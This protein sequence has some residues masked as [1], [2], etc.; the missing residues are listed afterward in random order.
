MYVFIP[1]QVSDQNHSSQQSSILTCSDSVSVFF[2]LI[3]I[4][5]T[6]RRDFVSSFWKADHVVTVQICE[7]VRCNKLD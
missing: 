3:K 4:A 6:G 7:L 1:T 5:D 2:S